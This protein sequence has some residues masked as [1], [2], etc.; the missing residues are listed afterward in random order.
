MTNFLSEVCLGL[1]SDA[2]FN[3]VLPAHAVQSAH[4]EVLAELVFIT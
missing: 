4:E 3:T 1:A 2:S